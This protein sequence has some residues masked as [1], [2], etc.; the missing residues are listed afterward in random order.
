MVIILLFAAGV[1]FVIAL[2]DGDKDEGIFAYIE[3]LVIL[4]ILTANAIVGVW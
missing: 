2:I 4:T 3:P 1:S